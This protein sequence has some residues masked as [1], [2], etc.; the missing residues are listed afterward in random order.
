MGLN[1]RVLEVCGAGISEL[2]GI[3]VPDPTG[4]R[5]SEYKVYKQLACTMG[6]RHIRS[7]QV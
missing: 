4:L 7:Y 2:N 1:N 6:L 3:Y 5:H